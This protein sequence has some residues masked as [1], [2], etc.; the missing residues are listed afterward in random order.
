MVLNVLVVLAAGAVDLETAVASGQVTMLARGGG[1]DAIELELRSTKALTLEVRAG[2][3]FSEEG[4]ISTED[5]PQQHLVVL[6]PKVVPLRADHSVPVRLVIAP[7]HRWRRR[8]PTHSDRFQ[9]GKPEKDLRDMVRCFANRGVPLSDRHSAVWLKTHLTE[10][11][12]TAIAKK[13]VTPPLV[14]ECQRQTK[15]DYEPCMTAVTAGLDGAE[16]SKLIT[17]DQL[18][19]VCAASPL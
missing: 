7:V 18:L 10:E 8:A 6:E 14:A 13:K 12:Q 17:L 11:A 2:M 16:A 1:A 9:I 15:A 4:G 3:M 19:A 5:N